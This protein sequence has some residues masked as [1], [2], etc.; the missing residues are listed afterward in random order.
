MRMEIQNEFQNPP[1][2]GTTISRVTMRTM[3]CMNRSE[4]SK[5]WITQRMK[6]WTEHEVGSGR[7]T[8][9]KSCCDQESFYLYARCNMVL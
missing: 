7:S 5:K 9:F 6:T 2:T 4:W 3:S 1:L 8:L